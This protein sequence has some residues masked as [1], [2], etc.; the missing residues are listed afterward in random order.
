MRNLKDIILERLRVTKN[1]N[2]L[3]PVHYNEIDEIDKLML[4]GTLD[5]NDEISKDLK[6]QS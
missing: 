3:Y 5:K 4:Y 6:Y 1:N 2:V